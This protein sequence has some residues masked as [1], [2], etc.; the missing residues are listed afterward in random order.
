MT[1]ILTPDI[2]QAL[3]DEAQKTAPP[4]EQLAV[5]RLR[6]SLALPDS[7][8]QLPG[9]S[10][11]ELAAL[12][13]IARIHAIMGSSSHLGPSRVWQDHAEELAHEERQSR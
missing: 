12:D 11:S 1:I 8:T 6:T 7:P 3:T 10:L 13:R 9:P 4:P 2:E 5:E